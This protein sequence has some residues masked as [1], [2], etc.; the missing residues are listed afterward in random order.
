MVKK[1]TQTQM[2]KRLLAPD[3]DELE[4]YKEMNRQ[5]RWLIGLYFADSNFHPKGMRSHKTR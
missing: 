4:Q 5:D 3:I 1:L 2:K